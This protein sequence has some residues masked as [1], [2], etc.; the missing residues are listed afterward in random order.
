MAKY[1]NAL[2]PD[3]INDL[4]DNNGNV[5]VDKVAG[6]EIAAL[7]V[8][9]TEDNIDGSIK[10]VCLDEEPAE[11]FNGYVYFING[12]ITYPQSSNEPISEPVIGPT[13]PIINPL[14]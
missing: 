10:F 9:P 5:N 2:Y 6:K 1:T 4:I 11:R 3:K 13:I 14:P 7:T 12:V 8:A